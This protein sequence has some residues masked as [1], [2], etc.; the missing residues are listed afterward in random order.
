MRSPSNSAPADGPPGRLAKTLVSAF[1]TLN[2]FTVL[3]MNRPEWLNDSAV[4]PRPGPTV[5]QRLLDGLPPRLGYRLRQLGWLDRTYAYYAGL[6]ARWQMFGRLHRYHWWSV[7]KAE[8]ADGTRVTLPL[9]NQSPRTFWERFLF[10]F[11]EIKFQLN[12]YLDRRR[13]TPYTMYLF[14]QYPEH[15]GQPIRRVVWEMHF[16][17][18]LPPAAA[19]RFGHPLHPALGARMTPEDVFL[20]A[21]G[22]LARRTP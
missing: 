10:D 19:A 12:L 7:V 21:D 6:D 8:Y 5:M 18:L 4:N 1:A 22:R 13:R 15:D 17:Q 11:K 20:P 2:V 9:P 16:Q 3:F 14:R